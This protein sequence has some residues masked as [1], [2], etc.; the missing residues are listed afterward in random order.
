MATTT[1]LAIATTTGQLI[2]DS[3]P[4]W[5]FF[6]GVCIVFGAMLLLLRAFARF[7]KVVKK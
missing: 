3:I 7:I 4:F 5:E 6:F 1:I 2:Q